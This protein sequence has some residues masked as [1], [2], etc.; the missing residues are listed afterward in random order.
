M[1]RSV[2][3]PHCLWWDRVYFNFFIEMLLVTREMFHCAVKFLFV[4]SSQA[5]DCFPLGT[6]QTVTGPPLIEH[7]GRVLFMAKNT[8]GRD[9]GKLASQP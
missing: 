7:L 1:N 9:T 5:R 3:Q 4:F 8:R 6:V 2:H